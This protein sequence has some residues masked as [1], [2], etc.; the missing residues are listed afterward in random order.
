MK[1][2]SQSVC[3]SMLIG[4]FTQLSKS[5]N[6]RRLVVVVIDHYNR[7]L[8]QVSI[9]GKCIWRTT[10]GYSTRKILD[11]NTWGFE[12]TTEIWTSAPPRLDWFRWGCMGISQA[13]TS[14][15]S[16]WRTC[17]KPNSCPLEWNTHQN[18]LG[19]IFACWDIQVKRVSKLGRALKPWSVPFLFYYILKPSCNTGVCAKNHTTYCGYERCNFIECDKMKLTAVNLGEGWRNQPS[20]PT[21]SWTCFATLMTAKYLLL[22]NVSCGI[23]GASRTCTCCQATFSEGDIIQE[24][25]QYIVNLRSVT[26]QVM[27][28]WLHVHKNAS[29]DVG[30]LCRKNRTGGERHLVFSFQLLITTSTKAHKH[31]H[32]ICTSPTT[33]VRW[34]CTPWLPSRK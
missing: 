9:D 25:I 14:Q 15:H 3:F 5:F 7:N 29:A 22:A 31:D 23:A 24:V 33:D 1:I 6:E 2:H 18:S 21:R 16:D 32:S 28:V 34:S 19:I 13:T 8:T 30:E 26:W 27:V 12:L 11:S 17:R 10:F 20:N 4:N